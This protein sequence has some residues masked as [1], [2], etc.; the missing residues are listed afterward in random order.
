MPYLPNPG[1]VWGV[2]VGIHGSLME[3][4]AQHQPLHFVEAEVQNNVSEVD[5]EGEN[6][7]KLYL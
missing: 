1:A 2:N 4:L 7:M 5:T 6:W 3:C